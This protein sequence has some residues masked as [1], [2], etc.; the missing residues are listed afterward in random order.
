VQPGRIAVSTPLDPAG[1]R[2]GLDLATE[3]EWTSGCSLASTITFAVFPKDNR[4]GDARTHGSDGGEPET[5]TASELDEQGRICSVTFDVLRRGM[6]RV[7]CDRMAQNASVG[8]LSS[9]PSSSPKIVV[10]EPTQS[11]VR[12]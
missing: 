7:G 1:E 5:L 4:D 2:R 10:V 3:A 12:V 11:S 9:A 8:S 6:P